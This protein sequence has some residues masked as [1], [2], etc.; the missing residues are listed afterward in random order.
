MLKMDPAV[1]MIGLAAV[2]A[3][4]VG[5]GAN[6]VTIRSPD[7]NAVAGA[8]QAGS[9]T[10]APQWAASAT[11]RVEPKDG[12]IRISSQLPGRIVE[13]LAKTNDRVQSGDL[14]ARLDDQEYY[15]KIAAAAA[16]T[17]VR[18]REREDEVATGLAQQRREAEDTVAKAE[19]AVYVAREAFDAM[20]RAMKKGKASGADTAKAHEAVETAKAALDQSRAALNTVRASDKMPLETRMPNFLPPRSGLSARAFARRAR[21]RCSTCW[22]RPVKPRY[23]RLKVR[24]PFWVI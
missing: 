15:F 13:V 10:P 1:T 2:L 20:L 16:E 9:T 4:A 5:V 7:L 14:L 21:A 3:I 18:E 8:A 17:G 23:R 11:G 6:N 19:R 24:L 22:Q 12:E